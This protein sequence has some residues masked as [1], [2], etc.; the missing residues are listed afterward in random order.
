MK[1]LFC[2]LLLA[3]LC[4]AAPASGETRALLIACSDFVTQPAL[5]SAISGNLHLIG[6][7]LIGAEPPLEGISIEDGTIGSHE[8]LRSAISDAFSGADENDLALLYICTHGILPSADDAKSYLL[9]SNGKQETAVSADD[10]YAMLGPV[11]GEKLL[12]IDACHSGAMIGRSAP[13]T[14]S[15]PPPRDESIHV[16]TSA[17]ASESSW[18]YSSDQLSSGAMSYF[19][20]AFSAGIGLYGRPEADGNGDGSVTLAE[21]QQ[22][23]NTAVPSSSCQLLSSYA[24]GLLLPSAQ[25]AMLSRPLTGFTYGNSLLKT[26]EAI[27]EFFFTV[28]QETIVQYRLVDY[29]NGKWDWENAKT[30]LD[31]GDSR[32]GKLSPGRKHRALTLSDISAGDSGYLMLQVFSVSKNELLLC[33]ERLIA[34]QPAASEAQLQ[35][36]A[37]PPLATGE[38]PVLITPGVPAEL[39]VSVRDSEGRLIRRLCS[40]QLTRPSADGMTRLYWDGRDA[41]GTRMSGGTFT[42]TVDAAIGSVRQKAACSI[43]LSP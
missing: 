25:T 29:D 17:D 5:G 11:Q 41:S 34:V 7:A 35:I 14:P 31:I 20:S 30:F 38:I 2:L 12:I 24:D 16:L 39:T 42:I 10:L 37:G 18:Y 43:H 23:L 27:F 40:S 21:M 32:S 13:E 8:S 26:D 3:A 19:A 1:R 9:L 6:S 22:Y 36:E 4:A 15:L 28:S 33:S